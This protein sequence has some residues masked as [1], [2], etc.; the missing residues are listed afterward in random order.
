M[1]C[2]EPAAKIALGDALSHTA[3][4]AWRTNPGW[5]LKNV[6]ITS[7]ALAAPSGAARE[8]CGVK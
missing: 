5:K 8:A 4:M 6:E 3:G 2:G 1:D 7:S